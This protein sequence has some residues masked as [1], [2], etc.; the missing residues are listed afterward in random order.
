MRRMPRMSGDLFLA[1]GLAALLATGTSCNR[2]SKEAPE[3]LESIEWPRQ[4]V[5]DGDTLVVYD[6][7]VDSWEKYAK[8][9]ARSAVAVTPRGSSETDFGIIEYEM[10]TEI[11]A[12]RR[13]VLFHDR[14]LTGIRFTG[15]EQSK[16]SRAEGIVRR[17]L[18]G[19]SIIVPLDFVLAQVEQDARAIP[20]TAVNL[21]PPPIYCAE[22][23]AIL[24]MYLGKPEF[25]P[26][27]GTD[28]EFCINTNWD[29]FLHPGTEKYFL[30]N[31][32]GW[33]T[34]GDLR[35]GPWSYATSLPTSMSA[36]PKDENWSEVRKHVPGRR[37]PVPTVFY[38][39]QPAE[40]IVLEGPAKYADIRGTGLRYVTN[41]TSDLFLDERPNTYYFLTAG[42]WF[43]SMSLQGPWTTATV[44]LPAD[45]AKIPPDSP[46]GNVLASVPGT[47][48]AADA[49]LLADV[50]HKATVSRASVGVNPTYDGPPKFEAIPGTTVQYALNSPYSVFLVGGKYYCCQNAIWFCA[51]SAGGPWVVCSSVPQAIYTI[52]PSHPTY[53][54]TYVY[55]YDSTPDVV[56]MG[57]TAGY[58]GVYVSSGVVVYGVGYPIHYTPYYYYHYYPAYYGYG[59]AM[60]YSYAS[61]TYYRSAQAY[62]PYGGAGYATA[63]N[64][65]TGTYARGAYAYGPYGGERHAAQSY[66]PYTGTYK[67]RG[68]GSTPYSSW[69]RGVVSQGGEWARGGYYSDSRGTV[70]GIQTS[71][72][73]AAV[74]V[75]T[76]D[77][78]A[79]VART[80][81][82]DIYASKDG[83]V[84]K[85]ND[86]GSWSSPNQNRS[87]GSGQASKG[88]S[89]AR[90]TTQEAPGSPSQARESNM[91]TKTKQTA[92]PSQTRESA[93]PSQTR[94]SAT[95]SRTG[96]PAAPSQQPSSGR[97]EPSTGA[98]PGQSAGGKSPD[99]S[100]LDQQSQSRSRGW[101]NSQ[102]SSGNYGGAGSGG[103]RAGGGGGR[104]R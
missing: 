33:I 39:G 56:V 102:R 82:G 27:P 84:Y 30:L 43:R 100:E 21:N 22:A 95:P 73:G 55:V 32:D 74:G 50:P 85:R 81:N 16:A 63:Y 15:L 6:P 1:I 41:T 47:L 24:T 53:N 49:V 54:V 14:K 69:E 89:A 19:Q 51:A 45:F 65:Y 59:C 40:L 23:P 77:G 7:Q 52:P 35:N 96:E 93:T 31:G 46:K 20:S 71:Q 4:Y 38:T 36:L 11:D 70:G 88:S 79:A 17:A 42:R 8:V 86:D 25:K 18:T 29:V 76:D 57:Y 26:L 68:G 103:G 87:G 34:T 104:G 12:E 92:A 83:N 64:P 9:S 13:E 62:G 10:G 90:P 3:R 101:E 97:A 91:A 2:A 78:S 80:K 44:D 66:N 60:H 98:T 37:I 94:E 75:K 28:L 48:E 99:R 72:G 67:A 61:G 5:A 58:M